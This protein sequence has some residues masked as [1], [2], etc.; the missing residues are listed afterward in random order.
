[1]PTAE[2]IGAE[3]TAGAMRAQAYNEIV[4]GNAERLQQ[5]LKVAGAFN[6]LKDSIL[7]E[8]RGGRAMPPKNFMDSIPTY[9]MEDGQRIS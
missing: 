9:S 2:S 6:E 5:W 1:M 8:K 4:A 3:A 7:P